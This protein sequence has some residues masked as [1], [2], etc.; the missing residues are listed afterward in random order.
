MLH[1]DNPWNSFERASRLRRNRKFAGQ[2]HF[3]FAAPGQQNERYFAIT[4]RAQAPGDLTERIF[5]P[6]KDSQSL[7]DPARRDIQ[8]L[9]GNDAGAHV[10][11]FNG[12]LQADEHGG[13][14]FQKI[15]VLV[16]TFL[17]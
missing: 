2:L 9:H 5:V 15:A 6:E 11:T 13:A 14:F 16:E 7:A 4:P 17:K 10:L 8:R 1:R 3:D 12:G